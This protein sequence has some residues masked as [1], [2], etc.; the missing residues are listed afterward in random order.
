MVGAVWYFRDARNKN[1]RKVKITISFKKLEQ[2]FWKWGIRNL[3][4]V[5]SQ[6]H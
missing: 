2:L 3:I 1:N 6:M 4:D 5:D